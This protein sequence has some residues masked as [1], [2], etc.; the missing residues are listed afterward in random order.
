MKGQ[1]IV[2]LFSNFVVG[3]N[4]YILCGAK[5]SKPNYQRVKGDG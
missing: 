2:T 3:M 4:L 1:F 5:Q